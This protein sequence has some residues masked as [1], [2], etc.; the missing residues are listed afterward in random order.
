MV[1]LGTA[2]VLVVSASNEAYFSLQKDLFDSLRRVGVHV[3][4]S[5]A[6]LDLGLSRSQ[7]EIFAHEG[8]LVYRP[9]SLYELEGMAK[10]LIDRAVIA[11]LYIPEYF[12]G[13]DIYLWMDCDTWAQTDFGPRE[14][15]KWAGRAQLAAVAEQ[16]P[17]YDIALRSSAWHFK[18]CA[19][20]FGR[21]AAMR[22]ALRRK[23]NAGVFAV[24]QHSPLWDRWRRELHAAASACGYVAPL[25]QFVLDKIRRE[26]E[27]GV[28]LLPTVCNWICDRGPLLWDAHNGLFT[29]P[30]SPHTPVS[31]IHLAGRA[32]TVGARIINEKGIVTLSN[33]QYAA[34]AARLQAP[35]VPRTDACSGSGLR[36]S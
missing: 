33:M 20:A 14:A 13:Y 16:D 6:V 32:K 36:R 2:A 23:I 4:A 21:A 7:I 8:V 5:F 34:V 25:D 12:P 19:R 17:H 35:V 22:L 30:C 3:W 24:A 15:V 9:Q 26:E 28:H 29:L 1:S 18:H 10:T 11:R 27:G 31:V